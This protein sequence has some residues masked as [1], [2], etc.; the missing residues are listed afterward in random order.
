MGT[1]YQG[2]SQG[3]SLNVNNLHQFSPTMANLGR[4]VEAELH[5]PVRCNLYYSPADTQGFS[6]HFDDHNVLVLQLSGEKVWRLYDTPQPFPLSG[7]GQEVQP[8]APPSQELMLT[9]GDVLYVPRGLVHEA[10]AQSTDS[11]HLTLGLYA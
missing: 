6:P 5:F 10:I 2:V 1:I 4:K 3:C 9:P 11:H 8:S 7:S